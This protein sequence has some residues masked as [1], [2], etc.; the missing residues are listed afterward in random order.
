MRSGQLY[1]LRLPMG[2]GDC[3]VIGSL[4]G[5]GRIKLQILAR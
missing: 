5:S 1:Q 3:D 4:S 2:G